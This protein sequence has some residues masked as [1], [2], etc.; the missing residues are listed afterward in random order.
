MIIFDTPT[1]YGWIQGRNGLF[2]ILAVRVGWYGNPTGVY[3]DGIGKRGKT[4]NGGL[5]LTASAMDALCE[6]WLLERGYSV[7]KGAAD[8]GII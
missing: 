1:T 3:I 2:D 5:S 7:K 8:V 6:R 4:I